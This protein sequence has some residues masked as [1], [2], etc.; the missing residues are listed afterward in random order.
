MFI[1]AVDGTS[2]AVVIPVSLRLAVVVWQQTHSQVKILTVII[3]VTMVKI[4]T[5][6]DNLIKS[7]CHVLNFFSTNNVNQVIVKIDEFRGLYDV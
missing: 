3:S 4:S 2:Q 7:Q 5:H 6:G 1:Q